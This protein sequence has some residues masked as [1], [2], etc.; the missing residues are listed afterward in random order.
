MQNEME[1]SLFNQ[2]WTD[3]E[4]TGH[5]EAYREQGAEKNLKKRAAETSNYTAKTVLSNAAKKIIGLQAVGGATGAAGGAATAAAGIEIV[6]VASLGG[7]LID[8]K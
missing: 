7:K 3:Y 1:K 5:V 6:T 2:K 4:N 8:Y